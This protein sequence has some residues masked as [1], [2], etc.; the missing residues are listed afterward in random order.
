MIRDI[1][2]EMIAEIEEEIGAEAECREL[3]ITIEFRGTLGHGRR[4]E[5]TTVRD[6]D[7]RLWRTLHRER[8]TWRADL[9]ARHGERLECWD[10][11]RV[12]DGWA[13]IVGELL[14]A[15]GMISAANGD[16]WR[17]LRVEEIRSANGMLDV[18]LRHVP[19]GCREAIDDA[20]LRAQGHALCTCE[21]CG[22]PGRVVG[23]YRRMW[24]A[25]PRHD[26]RKRVLPSP[27]TW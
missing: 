6:I 14:D 16:A 13:G 17:E 25:C 8:G 15:I 11:V 7:A 12:G 27:G 18:H 10:G 9:R 19:D 4:V 3:R 20:V 24:V 23:R 21:R 5:M 22:A 2:E 26:R 1:V